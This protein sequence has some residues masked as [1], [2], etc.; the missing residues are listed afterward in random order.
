[1]T[2]KKGIKLLTGILDIEGIKVISQR[3]HEGIGIILQIELTGRMSPR[4]KNYITIFINLKEMFNI[5]LEQTR[6]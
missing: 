4:Q 5:I 2:A 3:Q 1:M 6:S